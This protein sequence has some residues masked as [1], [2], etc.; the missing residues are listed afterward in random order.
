MTWFT[1]IKNKKKPANFEKQEGRKSEI[2]N[3]Y[4]FSV[5]FTRAL[6]KSNKTDE[7][8]Y[9]IRPN[10]PVCLMQISVILNLWLGDSDYR[11]YY[12]YAYCVMGNLF[13]L[14]R[15]QNFVLLL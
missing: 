10:Y 7:C 9:P 13:C 4:P 2:L 8:S 14:P 12:Y 1:T 5:T 11:V 6:H 15:I 3:E